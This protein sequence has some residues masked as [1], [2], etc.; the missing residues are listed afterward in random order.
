MK[1]FIFAKKAIKKTRLSIARL[2]GFHPQRRTPITKKDSFSDP[3]PNIGLNLNVMSFNIR[4]GTKR[5]GRNNWIYRRNLVHEILNQ[6]RHDVLGLQEALDF[7][8][9]EIRAMLPG[10][11]KVGIGNL[12]G[13]KGLH[14]A[15]FYDARRFLLSEEGT[16]WLSDTPDIPRS[17]GWGNIIPRICTWVRLIE[18][19]SQ[20]AFY[21]YNTHLDHLSLR[22]RKKSVIF[23]TQRI[24]TR[25]FQ[26][27]FVL[28]GDFN[29][30]E[31]SATIQYLKGK[32]LLKNKLKV[33][34]LNPTPLRDTFRVRYPTNRN[35]ATFNGFGR[36]FFRFKLDYIFVPSCAVVIDANIIQRRWKKRYPS[37]HFPLLAHIDLP[38]NFAFSDSRSF[39][40]EAV[41]H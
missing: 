32:I 34:V 10:Y 14:N 28:T 35:N 26:D 40:K 9:S 6:Y 25:S 37:D 31:K 5:D 33:K 2:F 13:S 21:F 36:Y 11:E 20:Q 23:L 1:G 27:P 41:N 18:K 22:S 4:R 8:I 17:K 16:F 29:A 30:R 15:I 3:I 24:H 12:G 39:F 7:Q 38:V 19:E